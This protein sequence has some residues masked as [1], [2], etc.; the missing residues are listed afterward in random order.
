MPTVH[1]L[2]R[3][4][5]RPGPLVAV[6]VAY[7][8][9]VSGMMIWRG[10]SVSPDYLLLILV[11]VALLSGRAFAF[12]RDWVPFVA[13]F[14]GYEALSGVAPKLGIKPQAGSMVHIER[15]LFAGRDPSEVLQRHFG[16]LHWLVIACTVIYFCHFLFPIAVGM[17]LWLVDR[18][19]RFVVALLGMSFAA[20]IFFLLV[21]TAPP[22]YANSLGLLPG[23]H[24]L[25]HG[26]LPS[27][28]SPYFQRLD[29]DPVAAFPSLHAAYPALGAL[30]LWQVSR[31]TALVMVPWCLAVWFSVVFL[32]QHYAMDVMGGVT[33]AA[34]TWAVMTYVVTPRVRALR[35]GPVAVTAAGAVPVP[36]GEHV[37]P[38]GETL[39]PT[40]EL[41]G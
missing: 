6:S 17:V 18:N 27:A 33:L 38:A 10:I 7:L 13:L 14:L 34:A 5:R 24:D 35:D 41:P 9:L 25:V 19:L 36:G 37:N 21:P 23:V 31:R 22:W 3:R 32:G 16:G 2:I 11:P 26:T 4:A 8:V 20:F 29:A 12:L 40:E 39:A 1:R 15:E 30:A 28:V